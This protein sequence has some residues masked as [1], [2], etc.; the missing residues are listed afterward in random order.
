VRTRNALNVFGVCDVRRPRGMRSGTTASRK[1]AWHA[2]GSEQR[3]S[4]RTLSV[5]TTRMLGARD[6]GPARAIV[7]GGKRAGVRRETPF[8][9]HPCPDSRTRAAWTTPCAKQVS[10]VAA[11]RNRLSSWSNQ[12]HPSAPANVTTSSSG[13]GPTSRA[14]ARRTTRTN[15]SVTRTPSASTPP[16]S[17]RVPQATNQSVTVPR[18]AMPRRSVS[19]PM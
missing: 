14:L 17:E 9:T 18:S 3:A 11:W 13:T 4:A 6:E 10:G 12:R 7:R 15:A 1:G 8:L 19:R 5:S 2:L 16:S